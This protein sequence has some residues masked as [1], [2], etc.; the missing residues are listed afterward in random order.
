MGLTHETLLLM[1]VLEGFWNNRV[2]STVSLL[3]IEMDL[4]IRV[5]ATLLED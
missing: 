1:A 5:V 2:T 4:G 3:L